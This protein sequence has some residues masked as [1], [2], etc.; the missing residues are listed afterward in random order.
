[1]KNVK[2]NKSPILRPRGKIALK[3]IVKVPQPQRSARFRPQYQTLKVIGEGAFGVVY[4]AKGP[5]NKIVAIKKVYDDPRYINREGDM[6][7]MLN[8]PN[9]VKLLN[10]YRTHEGRKVYWNFV[11]D[12]LPETL[13]SYNLDNY[14]AGKLPPMIMVKLFGFQLFRGLDYIHSLGMAHRDLKPENVLI[15]TLDGSLKIC[16]FGSA[17]IMSPFE[18]CIPY[19]ASRYYRAP[20]L[21]MNSPDYTAF[22][23]IWAAGCILAEMITLGTPLFSGQ[24]NYILL[25]HIVSVIGQPT[26]SD[27]QSFSHTLLHNPAWRQV[28]TLKNALP[29]ETPPL[30]LDLLTKIFVYNPD[31]RPKAR[32]CMNHPFFDDLFSNKRLILPSSKPFPTIE[33]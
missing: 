10:L 19:I 31:R 23:D 28:T 8:H 12:Y 25:E 1:M 17:K 26:E 24:S 27:L 11:M 4:T 6:L 9:C 20:E 5:G 29:P 13:Y 33:R 3:P 22:I 2:A 18:D 16:D 7:K 30:L 14:N 15:N 32:D 21:L